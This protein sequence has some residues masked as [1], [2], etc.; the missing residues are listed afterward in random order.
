MQI[1][2]ALFLLAQIVSAQTVAVAAD[3]HSFGEV[4]LDAPVEHE[5]QFT[6]TGA[7]ALRVRNVELTPPLI[8]TKMKGVIAPNGKGSVL[9]RLDGPRPIGKFNGRIQVN[10]DHPETPPAVFQM[11]G[12]I[13]EAIEF[14]PAKAVFAATTRGT[15]REV[16]VEIRNHEKERLELSIDNA[17][18]VHYEAKLETIT[19][20]REFR[21]VVRLTGEGRSGRVSETLRLW[22]SNPNYRMIDIAVNSLLN[23]RVYTFPPEV[24][25][26]RIPT[27]K[28]KARPALAG[29]IQA[30]LMIYQRGGSDFQIA[31]E[32][33]VP[34]LRV[35]AEKST[36]FPDRWQLRVLLVPEKLKDGPIDGGIL[37]KTN[38][39]EFPV[40]RIPV[41]GSVD[42]SW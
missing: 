2:L 42:G 24:D 38:D 41:L 18:G 21:L 11:S 34:F 33:Q 19:P 20:G 1:F 4:S 8:V 3:R 28:I 16:F 7:E 31:A 23:E 15:P 40:V 35:E 36:R 5:F 29:A 9:V 13:V 32:T 6:N 14:R 37:V 17:S 12:A 26:G 10:F 25:L 22:S 27:A 39:P 30:T